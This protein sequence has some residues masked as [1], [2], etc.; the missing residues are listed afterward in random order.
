MRYK[1]F[2]TALL[3]VLS[4]TGFAQWSANNTP[5]AVQGALQQEVRLATD[6][7]GGAYF[8]WIDYRASGQNGDIYAQR[9]DASGIAQWAA[10]GVGI[11]T[12]PLDQGAVAVADDGAGGAI[13]AWNDRRSG[14][15]D[16]YAQKLDAAG[17]VAWA[18][19]GIAVVMKT[20]EQQDARLMSD[21][22][23]G[24]I[25]VWQDSSA[26]GFDV[27]AQR[28][29]TSGMPLWTAGGVA[30]CA[31]VGDQL[32]PRLETDGAGGAIITWQDKRGGVSND[33]YAQRIDAN[34]NALWPANG[35]VIS[36]A[37][38]TQSNPKIEPDGSGGAY[39]CW[40]DKRSGNFDVYAQRVSNNGTILW[41]ANGVAICTNVGSQSAIDMTA[42]GGIDG[43]IIAWKDD[44]SGAGDIYVRRIN[45]AGAPQWAADG[46]LIGNGNGPEL[47]PNIV[48][49]GFGNAIL[50]WQDSSAGN[51]NIRSSKIDGNGTAIWT[52]TV[53]TAA[54]NQTNPKNV[55]DGAGG[56]IYGWQ[57]KRNTVDF[58]IYAHHLNEQGTIS[59][60]SGERTAIK[61]TVAPNPFSSSAVLTTDEAL[62]DANVTLVNALGLQVMQLDHVTGTSID[63]DGMGLAGGLYHLLITQDKV[64]IA[65]TKVI[66][67]H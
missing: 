53:T 16:I 32:N 30:I 35:M 47:K 21:G 46:I 27:Y 3:S 19:N 34:G 62:Q 38:G 51:W 65:S 52:I 20:G 44:R 37:T 59:A 25:V 58:D 40:Q 7:Q 15:R 55:P 45:A 2:A 12:Q 57:D 6:A 49:D 48:G 26:A 24:A 36:N 66:V 17:N 43:A 29:S 22:A 54:D 39:I 61:M 4:M 14:N 63:L 33:V 5:V 67:V 28:I 23:G 10:N 9:L 8:C 60:L 18:T 50:C 42:K 64:R 56:C 13:L 41:T 1:I 31:A 11:C